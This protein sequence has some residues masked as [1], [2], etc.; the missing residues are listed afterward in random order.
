MKN[1]IILLLLLC[2]SAYSF[3]Q[4]NGVFGTW[5]TVNDK[6][7]KEESKV[8]VFKGKDGKAYGKIIYLTNPDERGNLCIDCK[9]DKKDAPVV[10][11]TIIEGLEKKGSEYV[12]GTVIDPEDGKVY[13][14]KIWREGDSLKVRGYWGWL[15]RTQTWRQIK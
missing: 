9:G 1:T 12:N 6:T 10:G 5:K 13:D 7:G 8:Q 14:C 3:G 15:Y 4:Y 11:M 2:T